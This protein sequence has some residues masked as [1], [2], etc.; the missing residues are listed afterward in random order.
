MNTSS[1]T[2]VFVTFSKLEIISK[3]KVSK[4]M[5]SVFMDVSTCFG[6]S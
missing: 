6:K 5:M 4:Q 2:F 1:N 3:L